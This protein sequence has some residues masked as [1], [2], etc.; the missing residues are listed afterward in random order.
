MVLSDPGLAAF[1]LNDRIVGVQT[2]D[3]GTAELMA[4]LFPFFA[5]DPPTEWV[6]SIHQLSSTGDA[7]V[8]TE[9]GGE[10]AR[11]ST[12]VDAYDAL[13]FLVACDLLKAL[14]D[15]VHLHASGAETAAGAVL[16]IGES[17]AGKSSLALHWSLTGLPVFGDD[18]VL[19][20]EAATVHP[21]QR[22]FDIH[23]DRLVEYDQ[24]MAPDL[25]DLADGEE[26]WFDPEVGAGW[27]RPTPIARIAL[28]RYEPDAP[29]SMSSMSKP[30]MLAALAASAM[31]P[32]LASAAAFDRLIQLCRAAETVKVTFGD[33]REAAATLA[34]L[35]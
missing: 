9:R 4:R 26:V 28:I 22:L 23:R 32:G 27:A 7:W 8:V 31:A 21:F 33:S 30:E 11:F 14:P 10:E 2:P 3:A 18:I 13:E 16:A 19:L 34:A 6:G 35:S 20:D 29:C 24:A 1:A 5:I 12:R 15:F 25:A 17:G